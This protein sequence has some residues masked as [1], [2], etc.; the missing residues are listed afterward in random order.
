[1]RPPIPDDRIEIHKDRASWERGRFDRADHRIGASE[2]AAIL[3]VSPWRGP[4]DVWAERQGVY[5]PPDPAKERIFARGHRYELRALQDF[6]EESGV[7][8]CQPWAV[9]APEN[10]SAQVIVVGKEKWAICTPDGLCYASD[11]GWGGAEAKTSSEPQVWGGTQVIERWEES[12]SSVVPAHYATQCYWSLEVTGLTTWTLVVLLPWYE[13]RWFVFLRDEEIQQALLE[14]VGEWRE[15]HLVRSEPPDL[16]HASACGR[17]LT[18]RFPG[19]QPQR[20]ATDRE[21]LAV[22]RLR[23]LGEIARSVVAERD[24]L[25]NMLRSSIGDAARII[26]PN[27]SKYTP[28]RSGSPAPRSDDSAVDPLDFGDSLI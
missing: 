24:L 9:W 12:F 22:Q 16:S 17:W 8:T 4:W 6:A 26:L 20:E 3:G 2:V 7:F 14:S 28:R 27:G 11:S 15:R 1:M 18:Q 5:P 21:A 13:V 23:D 25:K 10:R 19:G